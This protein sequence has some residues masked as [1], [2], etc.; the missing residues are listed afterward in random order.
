MPGVGRTLPAKE[1]IV[2]SDHSKSEL[3]ASASDYLT[4]LD[5]SSEPEEEDDDDHYSRHSEQLTPEA[6]EQLWGQLQEMSKHSLLQTLLRQICHVNDVAALID[7]WVLAHVL[8]WATKRVEMGFWP[9]EGYGR[10]WIPGSQAPHYGFRVPLLKHRMRQLQNKV[11]S[12]LSIGFEGF[13]GFDHGLSHPNNMAR[14]PLLPS[15][16]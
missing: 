10:T 5:D 12:A 11:V 14:H 7:H 16:A 13:L 6:K 2:E 1:P 15:K 4:E 9:E 3:S 8:S